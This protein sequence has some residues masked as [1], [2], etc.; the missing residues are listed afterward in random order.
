[1]V[2]STM[3]GFA[4]LLKECDR[5]GLPA[6]V[7]ADVKGAATGGAVQDCRYGRDQVSPLWPCVPFQ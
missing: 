2:L 5:L 7:V 1:M 3:S 6:G 4:S